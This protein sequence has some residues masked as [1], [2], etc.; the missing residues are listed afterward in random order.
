MPNTTTT[1][2]TTQFTESDIPTIQAVINNFY[3]LIR[4][5]KLLAP[6]FERAL[7]TTWH[8]HLAQMLVF[9][10]DLMRINQQYNGDL[11]WQ[12]VKLMELQPAHFDRWIA[13]FEDAVNAVCVN[14]EKKQHLINRAAHINNGLK[15]GVSYFRQHDPAWL[16][17]LLG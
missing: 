13:L 6:S 3:Q 1:T 8:E 16:A 15:H 12:H 5:D 17:V 9:F 7:G 14:A 10:S 11:L 2:T 4:N